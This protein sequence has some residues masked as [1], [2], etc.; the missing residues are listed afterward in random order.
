MKFERAAFNLS[1]AWSSP[2]ARWQGSLSEVSSLEL[3]MAV[4]DAALDA[5]SIDRASI[6]QLVLGQTVPQASSFYSAPWVAAQIGLSNIGGPSIAQACATSVAC[7]TAAASHAD[8]DSR[9][10][11]IVVVTDRTSNGPLLIFPRGGAIGG[12]PQ[13]ENWV[14]DNF[15]SD[16]ATGQSML[17]TAEKTA[18]DG[19]MT[20]Q[21]LDDLTLLR[22]S[23]YRHALAND[24]RFQR[25]YMQPV[26][27]TLGKKV[28]RV[29]ADE[30]VYDYNA[31]ALKA[32][33]PVK[34]D[35]VITYGM[36]THPADGCAGV[37]IT[38]VD[39]PGVVSGS[40]VV[41]I[42]SSAFARV[43][44][45]Q[46]P[47]AAVPAAEQAL[48]DAGL[49]FSDI[50]FVVTHNPFAANDLWFA[51][52]T[53][54]PLERMNPYGSSLIYGHPQGPTGLRGVIELAHTLRERGGG[55]GL[56]TGCAAGDTG[57]ATVI[58]VD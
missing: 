53:G 1:H 46:M 21:A 11:H 27:L 23:Q 15:A 55:I 43:G 54:F 2:F 52:Q 36:Q 6:G 25:A 22:W 38:S 34:E 3:A 40:P 28:V 5:R 33:K 57:A 30:G 44:R 7:L 31:D 16:P 56:F 47:K 4:T 37:V 58:R 20:R 32:L 12:S 50:S 9:V 49:T 41:R 29:E 48:Q 14:L 45:A 18:R 26:S 19:S 24:R 42:L 51:Q 8:S 17:D 39:G 10:A 35:G 13:V